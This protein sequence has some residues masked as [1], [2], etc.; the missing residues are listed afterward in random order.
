MRQV[1]IVISLIVA[2]SVSLGQG[3]PKKPDPA[4]E[5]N[6]NRIGLEQEPSAIQTA[7]NPMLPYTEDFMYSLS[8]DEAPVLFSNPPPRQ[9]PPAQGRP[10]Q[11]ETSN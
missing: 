1:A 4:N 2:T 5:P 7:I 11:Q 3:N 8:K 9:K 6:E 10:Q